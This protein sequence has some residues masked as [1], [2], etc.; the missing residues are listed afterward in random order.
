MQQNRNTRR[1]RV[2]ASSVLM[3]RNELGLEHNRKIIRRHFR[4][5]D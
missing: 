3:K 1:P 5:F 4:G 2:L